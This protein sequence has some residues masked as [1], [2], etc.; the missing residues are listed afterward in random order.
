MTLVAD[1]WDRE[2][3]GLGIAATLVCGQWFVLASMLGLAASLPERALLY[4][5]TGATIAGSAWMVLAFVIRQSAFE[6]P[7]DPSATEPLLRMSI[8]TFALGHL[9]W[10]AV[11]WAPGP[12]SPPTPL[13]AGGWAAAGTTTVLTAYTFFLVTRPAANH[14]LPDGPLSFAAVNW[15]TDVGLSLVILF[16][17]VFGCHW[18]WL[19]FLGPRSPRLAAGIAIASSVLAVAALAKSVDPSEPSFRTML[20]RTTSWPVVAGLLCLFLPLGV[21]AARYATPVPRPD[22]RGPG[23][24]AS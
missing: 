7:T 18:I 8:L 22:S 21:E 9:A 11:L 4:G 5:R 2:A 15:G 10:A 3:P 1:A 17:V 23:V 12:V 20:G 13:S 19:R 14:G 24:T 6:F 16:G